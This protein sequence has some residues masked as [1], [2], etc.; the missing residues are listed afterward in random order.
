L[1]SRAEAWDFADVYDLARGYGRDQLLA[2]AAADDAGFDRHIFANMIARID[3]LSDEDLSVSPS[4]ANDLRVYFQNWA[5]E[6]AND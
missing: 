6:L 5:T 2:L 1:F 4:D 3:R